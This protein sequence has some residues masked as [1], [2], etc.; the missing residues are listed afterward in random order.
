MI[1]LYKIRG[2]QT[3]YSGN[4]INFKQDVSRLFNS[5]PPTPNEIN[6][7][8]LGAKNT[9]S[10]LAYFR[11]RAQVVRKALIWL[12]ANNRYYHDIIIDESEISNLPSDGSYE[13]F[14]QTFEDEDVAID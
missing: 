11:V 13:S 7:I 14:L 5:L 4:V 6:A 12:K 3:A 2:G 8:I 10:G 9:P 1:S